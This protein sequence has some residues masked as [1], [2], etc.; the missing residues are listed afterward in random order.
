MLL[1][2]VSI[3]S[4]TGEVSKANRSVVAPCEDGAA[5]VCITLS[6]TDHGVSQTELLMS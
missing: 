5:T 6:M 1:P 2:L 3:S 4:T